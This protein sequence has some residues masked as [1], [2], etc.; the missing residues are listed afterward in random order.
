MPIDINEC[1]MEG[2]C[3]NGATCTN[4]EGGYNCD[5]VD[6]WTGDRCDEGL[7]EVTFSPKA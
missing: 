4:L 3:D 7:S 1:D 6:G 5:C 2:H